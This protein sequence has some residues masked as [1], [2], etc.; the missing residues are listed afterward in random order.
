MEHA[1]FEIKKNAV[2]RYYFV[3]RI[4]DGHNLIV[5][6]SFS[7]RAQL[8]KCITDLREAAAVAEICDENCSK[9]P[10]SF[11]VKQTSEGYACTLLG[12]SGDLIFTG[13][14]YKRKEECIRAAN[15]I[16]EFSGDA[17]IIDNAK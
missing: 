5:T 8:E 7:K 9:L 2:G 11:Q 10:P 15:M 4:G 1:V 16:K 3:F 17:G 14:R 12:F 6:K 13:E